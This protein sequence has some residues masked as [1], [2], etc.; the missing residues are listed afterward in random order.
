MAAIA[1]DINPNTVKKVHEYKSVVTSD[2]DVAH[3]GNFVLVQE[4]SKVWKS[5]QIRISLLI[6]EQNT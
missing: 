1:A 2:G 4:D 6:V 3:V 5:F